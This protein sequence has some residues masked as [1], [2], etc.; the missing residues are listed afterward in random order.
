[1]ESTELLTKQSLLKLVLNRIPAFV[2]WK[3][4]DNIYQ[5]CNDNFA[6]AVGL[7]AAS[8]IVG[9]SDFELGIPREEAT[10]NYS[11]DEEIM[12]S[13]LE[14][15]D[16]VPSSSRIDG[17]VGWLRTIKMPLFN[18]RKE[19][20]GLLG[21]FEDVTDHKRMES[22]LL[23]QTEMLRKANADLVRTNYNLEQANID[24][25]QFAYATSHDL[26]EPLK[27]I[28]GF[29]HLI[30]QR[31]RTEL[32]QSG[33]EYL[34]YISE[35]VDR[36]SELTRGIL[37]YS[38]LNTDSADY[39]LVNLREYLKRTI[40]NAEAVVK[41]T[42]AKLVIDLPNKP[43]ACQPHRLEMLFR[44]LI[45]NAIKFNTSALPIVVIDYVE[46][47]EYWEFRVRDNG[48][49]IKGE[50][51]ELIFR[52]F[53]RLNVRSDFSGSGIGLSICKRI[54]HLHGGKIWYEGNADEGTDFC[55]TIRK[56]I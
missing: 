6:R 38:K 3:G 40:P 44:N 39:E 36:M 53:K 51:K 49:G 45:E 17:E 20:I 9:R 52:P 34:G 42:K 41:D 37:S 1:M 11:N 2:F 10:A 32:D 30:R 7:Q 21:T 18:D 56:K 4:R 5:G 26:Q 27:I 15:E 55:F 14:F 33:Q 46:S 19:V 24:L 54:V 29:S 16:V 8:Q 47:S 31:Y 25:E 50:Y 22:K 43:I 23:R 48:I 35:G 12:S 13:G 28:E